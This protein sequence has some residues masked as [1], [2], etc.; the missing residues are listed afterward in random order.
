MTVVECIR[1]P[2]EVSGWGPGTSFFLERADLETH[3]G[4]K[5]VRLH[6]PLYIGALLFVRFVEQVSAQ[7]LYPLV[8]RVEGIRPAEAEGRYEM[9]IEKLGIQ[10]Y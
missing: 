10:R 5:V 4:E 6:Q 3:E 8:Y 1:Q 2:V 9:R 7:N